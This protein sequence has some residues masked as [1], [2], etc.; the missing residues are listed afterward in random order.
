MKLSN[1][2]VMFKRCPSRGDF[3]FLS[4]DLSEI[5]NNRINLPI[6]LLIPE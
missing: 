3:D 5:S 6:C 1:P 2:G 4:I